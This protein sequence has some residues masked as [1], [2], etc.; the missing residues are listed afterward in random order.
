MIS[1]L[2]GIKKSPSGGGGS[3]LLIPCVSNPQ[4]LIIIP[5]P[6]MTRGLTQH[7]APV[8]ILPKQLHVWA[9]RLRN[10]ARIRS[11]DW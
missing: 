1:P 4:S 5:S 10:R 11:S 2:L 3:H 7:L 6:E 8:P 9:S